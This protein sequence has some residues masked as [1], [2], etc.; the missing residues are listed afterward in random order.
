MISMEP[1]TLPRSSTAWIE[2]TIASK[3][4]SRQLEWASFVLLT[5]PLRSMSIGTAP[6]GTAEAACESSG[7]G[8]RGVPDR[9]LRLNRLC[10]ISDIAKY[11]WTGVQKSTGRGLA[12]PDN[13]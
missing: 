12:R 8:S 11:V 5:R 4:G 13:L 3:R 1:L 9:P 10:R 6:A 2:L 7:S